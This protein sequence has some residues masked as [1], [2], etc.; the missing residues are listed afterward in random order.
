M[1]SQRL[2]RTILNQLKLKDFDLQDGTHAYEVPGWDSLNHIKVIMAVEKE[3]RI[4]FKTPEL[5]QLRN[6]GDLQL[7]IDKNNQ[8]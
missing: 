8:T 1:I 4:R 3:Y 7:L 5:L 6:I 2:K